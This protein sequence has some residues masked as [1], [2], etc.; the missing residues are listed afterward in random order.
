MN[1]LKALGHRVYPVDSFREV[2]HARH[3][4]WVRR[5]VTKALG[6][7]DWAGVN[8]QIR[9]AVNEQEFDVIWIDKGLTVSP[10]TLEHVRSRRPRCRIVG[11]SPDDMM[12][13]ENQSRRFIAGLGLYDIYFTTKTHGLTDLV[14]LGCRR[15]EFVGNAYDPEVHRPMPVSAE[16][17][18]RLGGPVGFIGQWEEERAEFLAH[19]AREGVEVR[20][21]GFTWERCRTRHPNLKIEN[22]PLWG[23]EYARA[24]CAF[25]IN[26]GFLRKV[27]RDLQT[28]RSIEIPACG[29]FMLAER[30][31]EHLELF[32]EGREAEFFA[33]PD[34]LVEKVRYYLAHPAERQAIAAAGRERCLRG[35]Y[36][37]SER[38]R[39]CIDIVMSLEA[40]TRS[41]RTG[42]A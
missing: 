3:A 40:T 34:E 16:D 30:T 20:I 21:W 22:V 9:R 24:I 17:R 5:I 6:P 27:N 4:R 14:A 8:A 35:R 11:Y 28:T 42:E 36:S 1:A 41:P 37:N 26:L 18:A 38:L 15:V 12:N 2:D 19:L 32:A 29:A 31:T 13:P 23:P 39:T 25:D 7:I 33:G 10:T